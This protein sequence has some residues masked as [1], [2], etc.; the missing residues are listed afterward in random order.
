V[1]KDGG[2][3]L[4]TGLADYRHGEATARAESIHGRIARDHS[5]G[6]T[7]EWQ[8]FYKRATGDAESLAGTTIQ[9]RARPT[10]PGRFSMEV[11]GAGTPR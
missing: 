9:W 2:G 10:G 1:V 11:Q 6:W 8:D 5:G 4:V 7:A 3:T